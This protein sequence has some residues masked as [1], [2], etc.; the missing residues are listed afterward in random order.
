VTKL[1]PPQASDALVRTA[2]VVCGGCDMTAQFDIGLDLMVRGLYAYLNTPAWT[3]RR[4]TT[5]A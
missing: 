5:N 4:R 1:L 3:W 2:L